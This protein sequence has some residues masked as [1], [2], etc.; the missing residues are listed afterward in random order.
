[1]KYACQFL[2]A[3]LL[4]GV[5][6]AEPAYDVVIYGGTSAGVAAAIQTARMGR[7][8]VLV[9]P[10]THL[11]GLT[12]NG[13]GW[14]DS[15]DK[16][17]I[18]GISLEFYQRVHEYYENPDAWVYEKPEDL[19]RGRG[20]GVFDPNAD[21]MW[22]FE[23]HVA[24]NI[25]ETMLAEAKVPI[26]RDAW[27]NRED[28][29]VLK[30]GRIQSI[31]TLDG[32]TYEGAMFIDATYEG[33]LMAAA[34]VQYT[35]GREAN[36]KYGERYNGVQKAARHHGHYFTHKVDPYVTPGDPASGVLPRVS[37]ADPGE[38]GEGDAR[39][40]AYCF[41]MCMTTVPENRV[42]WPKPD[43]YDDLQYEIL[44][45]NFEA[46]D[47]RLPLKIDM[48][49]NV[50]TDTNNNCAFST[51]NL[52]MNYD[53]P[54]ASYERRAEIL[55]EHESYQ[56]GLMWTLAN[57][58]RV[59]QSIRDKVSRWGLAKDEFTDN[60]NWP[61]QLYVRE[62]RRMI[63]EYVMTEHD[64]LR[65]VE[66][67]GSVGM[68][69]YTIDSH[70]VQRYIDAN[71][72]VQNEGDIGVGTGG[73]Y[74][75][76][77]G[78]LTPQK[79]QCANLLVPVCLSS[80]HSAY[81]SIRMEPVFMILGQS[82]A[83]A[84]VLSIQ[85]GVAVQDLPYDELKT[86]LLADGQRL[87]TNAQPKTP[88]VSSSSL[89]GVVV[90]DADAQLSGAWTKSTSISPFVDEGYQHN[91]RVSDASVSARFQTSLPSGKY[92]VR[93]AYSANANRATN[94]RVAIEHADGRK[95]VAL[96]EQRKP[97]IDG[98]FTSLGTYSFSQDKPAVVEVLTQGANGYVI[99]DA[100]QFL[101]EG[102]AKIRDDKQY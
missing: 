68:G 9:A 22:V 99:I 29:V 77:Y 73:P 57:H 17:A 3:L 35:V 64:C 97:E 43:D 89:K 40:Q 2:I 87:T 41:R 44:L 75:I 82:A 20:S 47:S 101:P 62:A 79:E 60:G 39:V 13:L 26:V 65:T 90:D 52:G 24:E 10:E 86:R 28:G 95:V 84:A 53:Y 94:I 6:Y 70:N 50:K 25:Y 51:D 88:P 38:D 16:S 55:A 61:R 96:N 32:K 56:K 4:T 59:P 100:V 31:A 34:G 33:D 80:S 71:G 81:G 58:P 85:D 93:F 30:E 19:N 27:L 76:A 66:T 14:T 36:A 92:E 74:M 21:S 5:C 8:V 15:G 7:S 12:T 11:G 45:R 72:Y 63:G 48:M 83:T 42:E 37:A 98:L 67:P 49:P 102:D 78:S 54:D 18:G 91:E 46:G 69:S 1:M 23:P